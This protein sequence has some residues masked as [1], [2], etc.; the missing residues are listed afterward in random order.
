MVETNVKWIGKIPDNW[1][2]NKIG[3]LFNLRNE[4]V[5]DKDY[6]PL[7]VSKGGIVPQMESV[8]KSDASDDRKLVLTG[9]FAINSRSD[10]KQSCGVSDYDGSV[11]LIN[12][13]LYQKK[14]NILYRNYLNYLLKN[15]GFAEEFYRWGHG[16]VADLW[17]T[18]WQEMKNIILP[19][20][21]YEN[22]V[23][24][25]N[26]LDKKIDSIDKL[27]NNETEQLEQL[28]EYKQ[29]I[30]TEV[31]TRGVGNKHGYVVS[32][33]DWIGEIPSNWTISRLKYVANVKDGLVDPTNP[34]YAEYPHIGPGNIEKFT[35]RLLDY[36]LVKDEGL[37]SG[38]YLFDE[39]DII[40][41]KINP[42]LGKVTYPRFKGLCSADSYALSVDTKKIE[43]EFL[44]YWFLT[45]KFINRTILESMRMG[46]PKI[47]REDLMK[48]EVVLP[49]LE[50]QK[51]VI[52][53]IKR[54]ND[55]IDKSISIKEKK[56][57]LLEEYKKSLIYEYVTGKKEVVA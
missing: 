52:N 32:G 28:R 6:S 10:R 20:P 48:L 1:E 25:T 49:S 30:I 56:I 23:L 17:T 26:Y 18:K 39:N 16:I 27:I 34:V 11:S 44:L 5:S 7:S 46:M 4:K 8:A 22:Q 35:G 57:E 37:I 36:K 13:V 3:Q 12:M 29:T 47:N 38:K 40:Y 31:M 15:H 54:K 33:V 9:D 55:I 21:S 51:E 19:F 43:I 42:Q 24:L 14:D 50:E 2:I 53:K 41:G 45:K